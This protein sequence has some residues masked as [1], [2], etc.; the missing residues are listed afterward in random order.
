MKDEVL[1]TD[2]RP[3]SASFNDLIQRSEEVRLLQQLGCARGPNDLLCGS[4][5]D[6]PGPGTIL[7][8]GEM[9]PLPVTDLDLRG[10][11]RKDWL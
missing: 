7:P 8:I 3:S 6:R 5:L 4:V 2:A 11:A 1:H 10:V 9:Q